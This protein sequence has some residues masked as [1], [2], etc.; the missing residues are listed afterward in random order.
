M[1]SHNTT[2]KAQCLVQRSS[3]HISLTAARQSYS[4][5]RCQFSLELTNLVHCKHRIIM[6]FVKLVKCCYLNDQCLHTRVI[7]KH[8]ITYSDYNWEYLLC[9]C[10]GTR[11]F[12]PLKNK[13]SDLKS[14]HSCA[15]K[16]NAVAYFT[17]M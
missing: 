15:C 17:S 16:T 6:P 7:Q 11:R 12:A 14:A 8:S 10:I 1:L 4:I 2:E 3:Q 13:L 9:K 5:F